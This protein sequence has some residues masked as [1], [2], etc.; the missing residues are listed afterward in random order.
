MDNYQFAQ[1]I[2]ELR[3]LNAQMNEL[4]QNMR[5]ETQAKEPTKANIPDVRKYGSAR[6]ESMD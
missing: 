5:S 3:T 4:R 2:Q 6:I 1:L